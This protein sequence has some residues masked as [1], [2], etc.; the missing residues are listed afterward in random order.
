MRKR[1]DI[2]RRKPRDNERRQ[3]KPLTTARIWQVVLG[4]F[5]IWSAIAGIVWVLG[6]DFAAERY[7]RGFNVGD[8]VQVGGRRRLTFCGAARFVLPASLGESVAC[9]WWNLAPFYL[10]PA[11]AFVI[12]VKKTVLRW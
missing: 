9:V 5:L 3:R 8:V 7:T 1:I 10:M 11:M 12:A 2:Y 4:L 6:M